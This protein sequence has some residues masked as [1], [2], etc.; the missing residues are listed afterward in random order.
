MI[1]D[2]SQGPAGTVFLVACRDE[3]TRYLSSE[4]KDFFGSMGSKEILKLGNR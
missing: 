1:R 3:C 4:A 2:I